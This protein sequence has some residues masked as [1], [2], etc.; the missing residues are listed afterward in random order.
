MCYHLRPEEF[1]EVETNVGRRETGKSTD[2]AMFLFLLG[3]VRLL[4]NKTI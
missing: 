4:T 1:E 2:E 3:T